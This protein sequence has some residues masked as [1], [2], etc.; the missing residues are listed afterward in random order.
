M[1]CRVGGFLLLSLCRSIVYFMFR[2][3][4]LCVQLYEK[5]LISVCHYFQRSQIVT[6]HL[7]T[8]KQICLQLISKV[9]VI[10]ILQMQ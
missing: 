10:I 4:K 8:D 2:V 9:H 3:H 6:E 1:T 5:I 7:Y